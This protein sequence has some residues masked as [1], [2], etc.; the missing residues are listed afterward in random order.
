MLAG[1]EDHR[2]RMDVLD[3]RPGAYAVRV[4]HVFILPNTDVIPA[5][6]TVF[7]QRLVVK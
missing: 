2:Y 3:I 6:V 7:E 5:A 1:V 4:H